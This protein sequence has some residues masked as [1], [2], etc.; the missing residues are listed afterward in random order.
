MQEEADVAYKSKTK[1]KMHA[2]ESLPILSLSPR[3]NRLLERIK[4]GV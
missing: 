1:G 2:C 3:D 4:P